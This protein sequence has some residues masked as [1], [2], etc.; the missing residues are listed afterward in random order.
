MSIMTFPIV[1]MSSNSVD[2]YR[3]SVSYKF[4]S[5]NAY[6]VFEHRLSVFSVTFLHRSENVI[7]NYNKFHF[8]PFNNKNAFLCVASRVQ[9][10]VTFS[11]FIYWAPL[12]HSVSHNKSQTTAKWSKKYSLSF[13]DKL[14]SLLGSHARRTFVVLT[15]VRQQIQAIVVLVKIQ[16]FLTL[17]EWIWHIIQFWNLPDRADIKSCSPLWKYK[18]GLPYYNYRRSVIWKWSTLRNCENDHA[19]RP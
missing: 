6:V 13:S 10:V 16:L 4:S 2:N 11:V 15:E 1:A 19:C 3:D 9:F 12:I 7:I 14:L 5:G 18:R 8:W 17:Y